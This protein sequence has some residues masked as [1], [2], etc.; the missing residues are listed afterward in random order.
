MKFK[1]SKLQFGI[2]ILL[3]A[4]FLLL[5]AS[6]VKAITMKNNNWIIQ[7]G[8]LNSG[9]GS[10]TGGNFKLGVTIGQTAQ[11]RFTGTNYI[12]RSGFQ[13][14]HSIIAFSFTISNTFVDFGTLSANNP[15]TRT[16]ILT[17]S[18]GSAFGYNVYAS[19]SSQLISPPN[20][21]II[22]DTTC[23]TGLCTETTSAAWTSALTYGF[24]YRCDNV[25][26]T[27]CAFTTANHY[28]Q[29]ADV[30]KGE[31]SQAVMTGVNVGRNKQVQIT[32]KVNVSNLQPAGQYRNI[33]NYIATPTF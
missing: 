13:Y 28:K 32:Y 14:I 21:A 5:V 3:V 7:F 20:G 17:V 9:A 4:C 23:D 25:T 26:G 6:P 2:A 18:N 30:S 15:V 22:P 27:D 33:I 24:G 11:G 19:E 10:P 1:F 12:V 16:T 29:F 8:N 31:T